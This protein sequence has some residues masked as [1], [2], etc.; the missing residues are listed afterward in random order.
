MR[1]KCGKTTRKKK[2]K[3]FR[4]AEGYRGGRGNLLRQMKVT[5]IRARVFAYRDRRV[6]KRDFRALWILRINAACRERGMSY[7][8]FI[9]GLT[10]SNL[11]LNRKTLSELAINEPAVFD[12]VFALV[13]EALANKTV[14]A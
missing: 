14:A 9:N 5:L 10:L 12:E 2:K 6:R 8:A 4:E 13:R 7:S 3:L 1:I 11:A